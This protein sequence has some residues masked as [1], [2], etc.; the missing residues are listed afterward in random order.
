MVENLPLRRFWFLP[1][2][3]EEGTGWKSR[4][5]PAAVSSGEVS[6]NL[7]LLHQAGRLAGTGTS[8]K[9]CQNRVC[10]FRRLLRAAFGEKAAWGISGFFAVRSALLSVIYCFSL[11]GVPV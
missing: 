4:A 9:T 7:P 8:Q 1:Q 10:H 3:G 2:A 6:A 5:V 11:P